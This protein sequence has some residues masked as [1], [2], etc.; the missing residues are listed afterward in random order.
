MGFGSLFTGTV[1]FA[2]IAGPSFVVFLI[3]LSAYIDQLQNVWWAA[4]I[5][6]LINFTEAGV[7]APGLMVLKR[8]A[9]NDVQTEHQSNMNEVNNRRVE[10]FASGIFQVM[11]SIGRTVGIFIFAGIFTPRSNSLFKKLQQNTFF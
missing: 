6:L 4:V 5:I 9:I 8:N 1:F 7:A 10:M 2:T 3:A 11:R